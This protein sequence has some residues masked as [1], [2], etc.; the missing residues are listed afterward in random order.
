MNKEYKEWNVYT[1]NRHTLLV[2]AMTTNCTEDKERWIITQTEQGDDFQASL[3]ANLL[4][5]F[6]QQRQCWTMVLTVM[7]R[8]QNH[9]KLWTV[10]FTVTSLQAAFV[11]YDSIANECSNFLYDQLQQMIYKK[12][13]HTGL[14]GQRSRK[15]AI[16]Y[17]IKSIQL[18]N[19]L[20]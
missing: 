2:I 7:N 6:L 9:L 20:K 16:N 12:L 14:K 10:P 18:R 11:R 8:F 3:R 4:K 19:P 13:K 17:L 1:A 15:F 5:N